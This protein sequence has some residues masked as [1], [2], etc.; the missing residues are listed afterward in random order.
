MLSTALRRKQE[1]FKDVIKT[2]RTHLMVPLQHSILL[3]SQGLAHPKLATH[4]P[5]L[6]LPPLPSPASQDAVPITFGQV[7][8][9]YAT[10]V[11]N[12]TQ[13]VRDALRFVLELALGGTAVGTGL[14]SY[15]GFDEE[16]ASVVRRYLLCS[17]HQHSGL[18]RRHTR[19][20][21]LRLRRRLEFLSEL[22]PTS[23]KL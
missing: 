22:H 21:S 19:T 2:G 3:M 6:L 15:Q 4:G 10:Q 8:S 16:V 7:F 12:G 18:T 23:L 13:H 11:E 14:N 5:L 17:V 1:E 20:H 9:G